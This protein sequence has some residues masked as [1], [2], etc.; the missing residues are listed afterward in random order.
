M[1]RG[2]FADDEAADGAA[3]P[4]LLSKQKILAQLTDI[5]WQAAS[6]GLTEVGK[7]LA[8]AQLALEDDIAGDRNSKDLNAK[9]R[10]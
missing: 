4:Q 7:F 6:L 9:S 3:S 1:S 10:D 8:V 2:P 5:R